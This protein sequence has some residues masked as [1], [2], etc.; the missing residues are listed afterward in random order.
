MNQD[1]ILSLV[2]QIVALGGGIAIGRGW[3]TADQLTL[4]TG[5]VTALVPLVWGVYA[6]TNSSKMASVESMPDVKNIVI[7]A[8]ANGSV[9]AAAHDP[10][11]PKVVMDDGAPKAA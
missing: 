9:G 11:R 5:I 6:H 4:I 3:L 2:R 8:G 10:S 7:E 1:Q